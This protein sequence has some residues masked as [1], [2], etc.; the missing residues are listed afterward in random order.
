LGHYRPSSGVHYTSHLRTKT[1]GCFAAPAE[2]GHLSWDQATGATC[3]AL[4]AVS[5]EGSHVPRFLRSIL[6][7]IVAHRVRAMMIVLG[8]ALLAAIGG[9]A[10]YRPF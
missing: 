2:L 1:L 6:V 8:A 3:R 5:E 7:I 9:G 10:S 4:P